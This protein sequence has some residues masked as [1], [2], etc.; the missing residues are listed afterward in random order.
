[1]IDAH[2]GDQATIIQFERQRM[3]QRKGT[4]V[5]VAHGD[6]RIDSEEAAVADHF[7]PST[8]PGELPHLCLEYGID[9][10]RIVDAGEDAADQRLVLGRTVKGG[11]KEERTLI[12]IRICLGR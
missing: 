12:G 11:K 2:T 4:L 6:E 1:M 8:P 3:H 5:F 7:A 9:H 10:R